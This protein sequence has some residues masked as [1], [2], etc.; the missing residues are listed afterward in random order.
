M[1]VCQFFSICHRSIYERITSKGD[2]EA[3]GRGRRKEQEGMIDTQTS[4][5]WRP[6]A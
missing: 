3:K 5:P 2:V 1:M 6:E 4:V